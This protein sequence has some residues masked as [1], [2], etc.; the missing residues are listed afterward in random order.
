[1][2]KHFR[3]FLAFFLATAAPSIFAA[4]PIT[5]STWNIEWLTLSPSQQFPQS[6]RSNQDFR[7]LQHYFSKQN[8]DILAF[9]E[10]DSPE[11]IKQVVGDRYKVFISDRSNSSN[12]A[13]QFDDINQYTG[14]AIS[15]RIEVDNQPDMNLL[16]D[17]R[18]KL[19]FA[20]YVVLSP[21]SEQPI[22]MLSVHLKARCSG[23]YN[24]NQHCQTLKEQ[25]ESLNQWVRERER[26]QHAYVILGD[27][28]H[29]MGYSGDWLWATIAKGTDAVLATKSTPAECK[30]RSRKSPQRVHQFRSLIDH[31]IVSDGL[32][33]SEPSQQVFN[34]QDV[35]NYQLSDHCP[36]LTTVN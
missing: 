21:N 10:V 15:K 34:S 14:F 18:R 31:I 23:R 6:E 1:M 32:S 2:K 24:N 29:N 17:E 9:Q 8:A 33:F 5:L 26:N 22:H 7:Q 11:A 35:L 36:V 3:K 20:S 25:G 13:L 30:V 28:N 27:F 19:R 12:K 4:Q 16:A